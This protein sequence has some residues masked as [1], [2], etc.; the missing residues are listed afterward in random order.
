MQMGLYWYCQRADLRLCDIRI[1]D[2][3][4]LRE[5]ESFDRFSVIL[6]IIF[7]CFLARQFQS[8]IV[9]TLKGNKSY[10][11]DPFAKRGM[12]NCDVVSP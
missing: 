4:D 9:S 8:K 11:L 10:L 1:E 12:N 3:E 5:L 7:V 6:I 2:A